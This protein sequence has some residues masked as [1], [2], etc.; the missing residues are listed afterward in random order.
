MVDTGRL[1]G[2]LTILGFTA[3][4]CVIGFVMSFLRIGNVN[5]LFFGLLLFGTLA[6]QPILNAFAF[7]YEN[8][9]VKVNYGIA[10][11]IGS[12]CYSG[13]SM[14]LGFLTV[15]LGSF[16]V[17]CTYGIVGAAI[18][19]LVFS[20]PALK[21]GSSEAAG[22]AEAADGS[23][24]RKGKGRKGE[25]LKLSQFPAFT[26]MLVGL[27]LVMLFHNMVMTYFI[28]VIERA[29]GDSSN[30]GIAI[31]I[32]GLV[33]IPVLFL[34]TK[35]KGSR[36]SK[37]FLAFSGIAFFAKAV[38]FL[39]AKHIFMIYAIQCLQCLAFGL[40]AASRVYYVDEVVGKKYEAT[41]QA[42]MSAT[43]T[44]GIVLGSMIG[45]FLM[46]ASGIGALL[47]AGAGVCGVG[48]VLMLLSAM[49]KS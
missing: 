48:M 49:R 32:A 12:L 43:E 38:L 34:Y 21:V 29:G 1:A 16:T 10:R 4:M 45:G 40:M 35:V 7:Y 37:M 17:P 25:T 47:W 24:G 27:S 14:L 33:E 13:C 9:G 39:F 6:M 23:A 5:M 2:K 36:P 15:R 30:M 11:G 41:G 31:G 22:D 28:H 42:F 44:L 20:M 46:D 8:S 19:L 18:F 26:M 3:A